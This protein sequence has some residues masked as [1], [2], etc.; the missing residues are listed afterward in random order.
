MKKNF[1]FSVLSLLLFSIVGKAQIANFTITPSTQCFNP[2]GTTASAGMIAHV[3]SAT[4]YSWVIS[5]PGGTCVPNFSTAPSASGAPTNSLININFGCCGTYTVMCFAY[6]T[7]MFPPSLVSTLIQTVNII[8]PSNTLSVY[9]NTTICSGSSTILH[10][11][12]AT[13]YTWQPGNFYGDSIVVSPT[14]TTCYTVTGTAS[15]SCVSPKVVCVNVQPSGSLTINGPNSICAGSYTYLTASGASSYTWLPGGSNGSSLLVYPNANTCYTLLGQTCSGIS[16]TLKCLSVLPTPTLSVNGNTSICAGQSTT[17][18]LSGANTYTWYNSGYTGS[19]IVLTP[20][21]TTCFSAYGQSSN[22]CYGYTGACVQ[23]S[24]SGSVVVNGPN[25]TCLGSPVT[26]VASGMNSYTWQPGGLTGSV[27]VVSPSVSTCYT[28]FGTSGGGC[29]GSSVKCINVTGGSS[30]TITPWNG[31]I[32]S[33]SYNILYASGASSY[34]WLPI[35]STS[36]SIIVTPTANTCYTLVGNGCSGLNYA[37]YCQS[38]IPSPTISIFGNDTICAGSVT[39]YTAS[40]AN[41]YYWYTSTGTYTGS[42]YTY[43]GTSSTCFSLQGLNS[44]GCPSTT[45]KC[46]S[47]YGNNLSISGP[48]VVCPGGNAV[49][50]AYGAQS[51][52]WIPGNFV[53]Q[54]I[55]VSPSVATCYTVLGS[56]N[57]GCSG[58]ALKCIS[59]SQPP[60]ITTNLVNGVL[61]SG[62]AYLT[63]SGANTYTWMPFN[64]TGNTVTFTATSGMCF[65][66][67][68]M[69]SAGCIGST[70]Q[71]FSVIPS[72]SISISGPN[73][74]CSGSST[75]LT[76]SGAQNYTWFP[77]GMS[78]SSV[79]VSPSV[80]SCYTVQSNTNGCYSYAVKCL[81]VQ[82]GPSLSVA[83]SNSLCAGSSATVFANG[84]QSY[85]WL[86]GNITGAVVVL[87]PSVSTCYTVVGTAANGCVGLGNLCMQVVPKPNIVTNGGV[88]CSGNT[89]TLS[90]SGASTYTWLPGGLTGSSILVNPTSNTCYTVIGMSS[91]GCKN[92]AINCLSVIATPDLMISGG[93]S[94]CAGQ[95]ASLIVNGASSYTWLPGGIIGNAVSVTP[96]VNTCYTVIGYNNSNGCISNSS[97][98]ITVYA[99]PNVNISGNTILC[100]GSSAN[101][102]ASG[103]VSYTW[104]SGSNSPFVTVTPTNNS[105]YTVYGTNANGCIGTAVKCLSVQ[106]APNLIVSGPGSICN[107]SNAVFTASGASSYTW[108]T[109]SNSSIISV[110]PSTSTVYS[111]NGSNGI[112]SVVKSVTLT[113]NPRPNIMVFRPDSTFLKDSVICAGN[114]AHLHAYGA[115]NYTWSN[116]VTG[117]FNL[118]TP[119]VTTTYSVSGTNSF[120]CSNSGYITVYVSACTGIEEQTELS[121][122]VLYPNPVKDQLHL[123]YSNSS[124]VTYKIYDLL[125]RELLM[126]E[127]IHEKELNLSDFANGTYVIRLEAGGV[128]SYKKIVVEK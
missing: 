104:N 37:V 86:P 127:F 84:A 122:I 59:I 13:N 72:P 70:V 18:T 91:N 29:S 96:S 97:K 82:T 1:I 113:V 54:T 11:T 24:N 75:T 25:N 49:L 52:T 47:V 3:P 36:P 12:G 125:G 45:G 114:Q 16:S 103:A 61:C 5:A 28:V 93:S 68:G 98:C 120:G 46:I 21:A 81:S 115:N 109:G 108:N 38:V 74:N 121:V 62:V 73:V 128:S 99:I 112:C 94:I 57:G 85:T 126:G 34:T 35:G 40:G 19:S 14:V 111:V 2:A 102:L 53:G 101:L 124:L 41:Y 26:L 80:S 105:C 60:S 55:V 92:S 88:Y 65:T 6:N 69:N 90:A 10:A 8:C 67:S 77:G 58:S 20:S 43:S 76:A 64:Q 50:T 110:S 44:F 15:A 95:S 51:Y 119:S 118:V 23:V 79:V 27:I 22:G 7:I 107:G 63:A 33:G 78:G 116:G 42:T 66:V 48:S 83:G 39:T 71:C 31:A 100:A 56:S 30:P 32:C 123:Q 117:S 106:A 4:T 17:L 9:G 89:T 87:T